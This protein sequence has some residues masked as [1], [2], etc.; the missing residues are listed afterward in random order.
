M[1]GNRQMQ[2]NNPKVRADQKQ[3]I[4]ILFIIN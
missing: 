3:K 1:F 4:L 2:L